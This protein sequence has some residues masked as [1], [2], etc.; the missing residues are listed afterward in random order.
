MQKEI[1]VDVIMATKLVHYFVTEK[2][3]KAVN[4][5]GINDEIWLENINGR[6]KLI[7]IVG[8]PIKNNQDM[9]FDIKKTQ[10]ITKKI[11]RKIMAFK[12]N[13][14]SFYIKAS[15]GIL[16]DD[17]KDMKFVYAS[18]N[19]DLAKSS[20]VKE[21]F[22]DILDKMAFTKEGMGLYLQMTNDINTHNVKDAKRINKTFKK[23]IPWI[24]YS[25][26]I[27]NIII[28]ILMLL[29]P[30]I[31]AMGLAEHNRVYVHNEYY[32]LITYAFL[33]SPTDIFHI[34]F[35]MYSIYMVGCQ[36]ES[37]L[38]KVKYLVIYLFSALTGGLLSVALNNVGSVGASGAIFGLMGALLYF[39]FHYRSYI[40][41]IL[42]KQVLPII[43]GNLVIGFL[44]PGIDNFG[45]IGGLLGGLSMTMTVGIDYK[46]KLSEKIAGVIIS[47]S[48]II[49]CIYLGIAKI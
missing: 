6:D 16:P 30:D 36:V 33:H 5:K 19:E 32:R 34:I 28:Y 27:I 13:V 25:L 38:G 11:R 23:K 31:A 37:Y 49:L 47:I 21:H 35:N 2:D 41:G 22:P 26:I 39:G 18:S 43:I 46:T 24:T 40:S 29:N 7:R 8:N 1:S 42:I 4:I 10:T 44:T 20:V 17:K 12:L 48:L 45:H 14:L 15:P 3:Y 9:A